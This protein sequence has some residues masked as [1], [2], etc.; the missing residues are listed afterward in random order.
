MFSPALSPPRRRPAM[1]L[2]E[3][4]ARMQLTRRS[5]RAGP[6]WVTWN[7]HDGRAPRSANL[8]C[9]EKTSGSWREETPSATPSPGARPITAPP[10]PAAFPRRPAPRSGAFRAP[11][12]PARPAPRP[13]RTRTRSLGGA[14]APGVPAAAASLRRPPLSAGLSSALR[15]APPSAADA[16]R[17]PRA[18]PSR[19]GRAPRTAPVPLSPEHPAR[20]P[21]RR[22]SFRN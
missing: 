12:R 22:L 8:F 19:A 9:S 5:R 16:P 7:I 10:R 17:T 14:L 1:V 3:T 11:F 15:T 13:H 21:P 6:G 18:A 4:D 20:N 2:I